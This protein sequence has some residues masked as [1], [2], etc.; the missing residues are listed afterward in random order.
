MFSQFWEIHHVKK[1]LV[2]LA[3]M[4]AFAC[5]AGNAATIRTDA[6]LFSP[7]SLYLNG[8]L[9][10]F[11]TVEV[12]VTPDPGT[13]FTNPTSGLVSGSPRPAGDAF[14]YLNRVLNGDPLDDPT[15]LGWSILGLSNIATEFKFTGG[16]LGATINTNGDLFLANINMNSAGGT[17]MANVKTY[18]LGE[19]VADLTIPLGIPEPASVALAGMGLLGMVAVRRRKA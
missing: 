18:R 12:T 2:V 8:G 4:S 11:D 17:G 13:T 7:L 15:F 19:I 16:P 10:V 14:T 6:D 5:T 9:D 3:M 1:I